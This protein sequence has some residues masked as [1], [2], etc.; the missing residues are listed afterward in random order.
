MR[1]ASL[2]EEMFASSIQ[3]TQVTEKNMENKSSIDSL[4]SLDAESN[5]EFD[6]SPSKIIPTTDRKPIKNWKYRHTMKMTV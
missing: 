5:V 1:R 4:R 2:Q 3:E 6:L